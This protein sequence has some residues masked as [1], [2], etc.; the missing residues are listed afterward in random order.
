MKFREFRK[1]GEFS[2]FRDL[3]LGLKV[4]VQQRFLWKPVV[5]SW[6]LPPFEVHA[7]G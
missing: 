4:A 7:R 5:G 3:R 6:N 1:F 2:G